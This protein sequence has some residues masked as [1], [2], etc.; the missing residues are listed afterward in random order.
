[1]KFIDKLKL[2]WHNI[3]Q[4]KSR[5]IIT[6][7]IVYVIG[8]M[9]MGIL[10]LGVSFVGN[11]N[12]IQT[13]KLANQEIEITHSNAE[14]ITLDE[15]SLLKNVF[16]E[17]KDYITNI[18]ETITIGFGF[19]SSRI[20][21]FDYNYFNEINYVIVE[22][23]KPSSAISNTNIVYLNSSYN[24]EYHI[25][26]EYIIEYE[27]SDYT[28]IVGGFLEWN[29]FYGNESQT[30][31]IRAEYFVDMTYFI[32]NISQING[33]TIHYNYQNE[34]NAKECIL[35]LDELRNEVKSVVPDEKPRFVV[36]RMV[37]TT[38]DASIL[39]QFYKA[40]IM[41]Y[42][43]IAFALVLGIILIL[44]SV[45]SISNT[46]T[47][48][49]DKNKKFFGLLKALGLKNKDV[50]WI[51]LYEGFFIIVLGSVLAFITLL[52]N[53]ELMKNIVVDTV[54]VVLNYSFEDN[55][56][57]PSFIM[58][59]YTVF[60]NIVFFIIFTYLFSRTTLNGVYKSAPLEVINEVK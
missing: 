57:A 1:M 12:E 39:D 59:Y 18:S 58:P 60:I 16:E 31:S 53:L 47:I 22:G 17:N 56:V 35:K 55:T 44:M 28:F 2:S 54:I 38:T 42:L 11:M 41:N 13:E 6:L 29:D 19:S 46:L 48:S 14:D 36:D 37:S 23:E 25:G 40:Y 26:D 5:S 51:V 7:I 33:F 21:M 52:M 15:I 45:G 8:L 27:G 30:I 3:K 24:Q 43:I 4:N 50:L 20:T 32:N 49:I 34:F 10:A 9:V